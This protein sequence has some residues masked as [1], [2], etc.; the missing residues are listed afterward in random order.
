MALVDSRPP[1][2]THTEAFSK[3]EEQEIIPFEGEAGRG[4]ALWVGG[5]SPPGG[6]SGW[7]RGLPAFV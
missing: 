1:L 7:D 3:G 6:P 2:H 4:W 5:P